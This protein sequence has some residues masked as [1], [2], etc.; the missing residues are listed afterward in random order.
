MMTE[1]EHRLMECLERVALFLHRQGEAIESLKQELDDLYNGNIT[2]RPK[3][4]LTD[5][6]VKKFVKDRWDKYVKGAGTTLAA[7]FISQ[8]TPYISKGV[9]LELTPEQTSA[10]QASLAVVIGGAIVK[11]SNWLKHTFPKQLGWL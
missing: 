1:H 9:G 6:I 2:R 5:W 10:L 7:L 11:G 3:M 8:A 4:A